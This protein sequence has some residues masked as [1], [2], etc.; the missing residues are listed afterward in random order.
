MRYRLLAILILLATALSADPHSYTWEGTVT[1]VNTVIT[2]TCRANSVRVMNDGPN[3]LYYNEA[4]APAVAGSTYST[5]L[6]ASEGEIVSWRNVS[7]IVG[8]TRFDVITSAGETTAA[9]VKA[10]CF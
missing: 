2:F 4:G 8:F 7:N 3:E 5:K 10:Y 6:L 1:D 9:R